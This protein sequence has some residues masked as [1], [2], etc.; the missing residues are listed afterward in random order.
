MNP[1]M[2]FSL[3]PNPC[4][5]TT[6]MTLPT[7]LKEPQ[8][9]VGL[10][11]SCCYGSLPLELVGETSKFGNQGRTHRTIYGKKSEQ[12]AS[13]NTSHVTVRYAFTCCLSVATHAWTRQI[14]F[15]ITCMLIKHDQ[16]HSFLFLLVFYINGYVLPF[17]FQY[18]G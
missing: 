12:M 9:P 1:S 2:L 8:G 5:Q 11:K 13:V 10:T 14:F 18:F 17:L 15:Y 4:G 16:V 6:K 3:N 7:G